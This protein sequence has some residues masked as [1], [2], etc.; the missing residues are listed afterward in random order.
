MIED[1]LISLSSTEDNTTP[2]VA[3]TSSVSLALDDLN[4]FDDTPRIVDPGA[5]DKDGSYNGAIESTE[6]NGKQATEK[7][8]RERGQ[9]QLVKTTK[10]TNML[11]DAEEQGRMRSK[12]AGE[13]WRLLSVAM[14]TSRSQSV[15]E[16]KPELQELRQ[17]LLATRHEN[18]ELLHDAQTI[19]EENDVLFQEA[20]EAADRAEKMER[21]NKDRR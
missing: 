20:S 14:S 5:H 1:G 3:S 19:F 7:D 2:L 16:L 13:A 10:E 12:R 6:E 18:E 11:H 17:I 15:S 8:S 4:S 9:A 21:K